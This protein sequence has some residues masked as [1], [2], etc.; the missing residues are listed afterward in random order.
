MNTVFT[1]I[2]R[3][4]YQSI[5]ATLV[6][7]L[8]LFLS[9]AILFS[10][11]FLYGLLGYV[12]TRP[13]VTVYFKAQTPENSIFQL[14]DELTATGKVLSTKYISKNEAFSIYKESNKDNPLLL[15]MVSS[16]ILPPS[17]E[18]NAKKPTY[19]PELAEQLKKNPNVDEVNF[20]K[21]IIDRLL[22][23]TDII[24]KI[25]FVFFS[26]LIFTTIIILITIMH[27]KVALKRE[28]IELS[29]LL[30]AGSFYIQRPFL[31][32]AGFFGIASALISFSIFSGILLY[33]NPFISSYIRGISNLSINFL[34]VYQL[35]VWPLNPTFLGILFTIVALFGIIISTIASLLATQK[36]IK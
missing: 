36:Y 17:L 16:D 12:E 32:E 35:S 22:T 13:Q 6:L 34:D 18:I 4:P 5:A 30:G 28:E 21:V 15:E 29:R 7:F 1:S 10:L 8:T 24:R 31:L 27:F 9:L 11:T 20:Q 23:L 25:S 2:R 26:F 14:R 33:L 3:T 19:L